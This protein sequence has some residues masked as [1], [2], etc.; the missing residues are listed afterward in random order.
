MPWFHVVVLETT[1]RT[2]E[3]RILRDTE[4][5]A[6]EAAEDA[7]NY[8]ED[9]GDQVEMLDED[10]D[11]PVRMEII[12]CHVPSE[13]GVDSDGCRIIKSDKNADFPSD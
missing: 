2:V 3:Y 4:A 9:E 6:R 11:F 1:Q 10:H 8:G 12:E 13:S 7:F 5:E